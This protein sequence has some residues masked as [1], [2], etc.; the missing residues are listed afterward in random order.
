MTIEFP[1]GVW[2]AMI[3]PL[4]EDKSIDWDGVDRLTDWYIEA[5]VA[6]L[7]AVG[8]SG[9]MFGLNDDERLALA[10]RVVNRTNG[11]IPVIASGTFVP[12]A[13]KQAE[14]IN[15]MADTGVQ[16]VTLILGELAQADDDDTVVQQHIEQLLM[17]TGSLPLALYE[18]PEPYHRLISPELVTWA[19][20]TNRFYLLKETSRSVEKVRAKVD[21]AKN[22]PL[23][24]FNAD[25]TSLLVSLQAG[26]KG[27]CGIAANFY[28]DLVV[29][30]CQHYADSPQKA[31]L[32]Q[33]FLGTAD[34]TIHHK[35]PV[36]AKY[37]HQC[38]GIHML[39]IS[40]VSQAVLNDY[41]MRVLNQI[42]TQANHFRELLNIS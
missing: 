7:F 12:S 40:R 39:P 22:S 19:A 34:T 32:I 36:C 30:L 10:R 20:Q 8:Q 21:A 38:A 17:R 29:W 1:S 28:P 25:A 14:F 18:C 26:A 6:G 11:R 33:A 13:E 15:K 5:G 4:K 37:Y 35:Y 16:A 42:A 31:E 27:Y 9:E 41:E 3:T 23:R 24:I 2:P